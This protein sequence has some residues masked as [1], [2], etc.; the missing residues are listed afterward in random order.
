MKKRYLL[1]W[2]GMLAVAFVLS[3]C[4]GGGGGGGDTGASGS[5]WDEMKWDQGMWK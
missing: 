4:G 3:A 2:L 5:N 1:M